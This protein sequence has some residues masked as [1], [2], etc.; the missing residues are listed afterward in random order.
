MALW[1]GPPELKGFTLM[2]SLPSVSVIIP[3]YKQAHFL[4]RCLDS[5]QA[6]TYAGSIE[7]IVID[8]GS[9]DQSAEVARQHSLSPTVIEQ[10]NAGVSSARN[11]GIEAA[12]GDY[13]A[14]LD[15]DDF[16]QPTKLAHQL[17]AILAAPDPVCLSFTRYQR[18][19]AG[20][21]VFKRGADHPSLKLDPVASK[22]MRQNFV[23]TSTVVVHR[24]CFEACGQFP[25]N[26]DL[27][28]AGQDFALWLRI[29][30]KF[31]LVYLPEIQ[32]LYTVHKSNR[33]GIN[34]L[35]HHAGGVYALR[36]LW[37]WDARAA[38][39][40]AG[41]PLKALVVWRSVKLCKD[42]IKRR[43]DVPPEVW[44]ALLPTIAELLW[45]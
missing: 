23:G 9:P 42:L 34:P 16:W 28:K 39:A 37:Q 14:F 21:V 26:R 30:T 29:A 25:A 44:R 13:M 36:A 43:D 10:E 33:V 32:T 24:A 2:S 5:V 45:E 15:A 19:D 35:K 12:T 20:G 11:A 18:V 1:H 4:T 40:A 41:M 17:D 3:A 7:V 38:R 8:D 22:L 6:Q 27:L 31:P